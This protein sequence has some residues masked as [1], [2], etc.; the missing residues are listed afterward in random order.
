MIQLLHTTV[1]ATIA[2]TNNNRTPRTFYKE[3]IRG[4]GNCLF[5]AVSLYLHKT[6]DK[7]LLLRE[8]TVK[9]TRK[10]W[11]TLKNHLVVN[12]DP[13]LVTEKA[14][15]YNM[16]KDETYGSSVE[17]LAMSEIHQ[18]NFNI[19]TKI[20][21]KG[22]GK[23]TTI[24]NPT[25]VSLEN[26]NYENNI[27][28][29]L[30]GNIEKGHFELLVPA[31]DVNKN[32]TDRE[33]ELAETSNS[34]V[35][36]K[37]P[38]KKRIKWSKND[39]K[40]VLWC[41]FHTIKKT[42][43]HDPKEMFN[44]WQ[45]RNKDSEHKLNAN[46][47]GTQLRFILNSKK[48]TTTE[49]DEVLKKV[50]KHIEKSDKALATTEEPHKDSNEKPTTLKS[51][52]LT[53]KTP[54][55]P[56]QDRAILGASKKTHN[57]SESRKQKQG[58]IKWSNEEYREIILR[59]FYTVEKTGTGNLNEA[60]KIWQQRNPNPHHQLNPNTMA[61]QRR[62]ILNNNKLT[63]EE[64]N[65]IMLK[66]KNM[67]VRSERTIVAP[68]TQTDNIQED[69]NILE[70]PTEKS[71][72]FITEINDKA[73]DN[74]QE[75]QRTAV[76]Q[77]DENHEKEKLREEIEQKIKD[78][79]NFDEEINRP[80]LKK[81]NE[82]ENA[83]RLI[84]LGNEI[85]TDILEVQSESHKTLTAIN[86]IVYAVGT[87]IRQKLIPSKETKKKRF[88][89]GDQPWKKRLQNK[90]LALRKD[91]SQ[92]KECLNPEIS[93]KMQ[94]KK[95]SLYGKYKIKDIKDHTK[96]TELIKQQI[97][98]KA[99][100]IKRYTERNN[101]F[102]QNKLFSENPGKFYN[103]ILL[104][105]KQVERPPSKEEIEAYWKGIWSKNIKHNAT[106][107]WI[108][109]EYDKTAQIERMEWENI[110]EEELK[111]AINATS[112]WKAPGMDGITN[113]WLKRL[114]AIH[115]P[116]TTVYNDIISGTQ[117]TPL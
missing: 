41:H 100:R 57:L 22:H 24:Q 58:R 77:T 3:T 108:Q 63:T 96:A 56:Q 71:E 30:S 103:N 13:D 97:S 5:R 12:V 7:H 113:F 1:S 72:T 117:Q 38:G 42:G 90:I 52:T 91:L 74:P 110:K 82:N 99:C 50:K 106:A 31:E 112:N 37:E 67:L 84:K 98:A 105:K 79:L 2:D 51:T 6:Q 61:N 114:H 32:D 27:N 95:K 101:Q 104:K 102:Q 44:I 26:Q 35:T 80:L 107:T 70:T 9:Y 65:E 86:R 17:M 75:V 18:I 89:E 64:L 81:I 93:K 16:R 36:N 43:K 21:D 8:E 68:D 4:D 88:I 60:Y 49:S 14:Y 11:E 46:T 25:T 94:Y 83:K 109:E 39:Y 73:L 87:T 92:L 20:T 10:N 111:V 85:I 66:A 47:L 115:K 76:E 29:L 59:H 54:K 34:K 116:L 28:L 69:S 33:N 62:F 78:D 55:E 23:I 48:I 45:K 19:F 15:C 40:E 53:I